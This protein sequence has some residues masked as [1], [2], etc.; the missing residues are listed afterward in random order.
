M[1]VPWLSQVRFLYMVIL[2]ITTALCLLYVAYITSFQLT[3]TASP[4]GTL[5]LS[6]ILSFEENTTQAEVAKNTTVANSSSEAPTVT[7][8]N[9]TPPDLTPRVAAEVLYEAG[10]VD[11]GPQIC[12]DF[13]R[14]LKLLI[15]ITSAPGHESARM[16]IRETW[17]HFAIRNDVAVAFMLGLISNETVNAKIEKEQDLYGDLIRGKFTDTYDNLTL[18]TISLLEWV[19]NYCPEA[20]FLLKTDDDMFINVS[21]LLDFIA[22]RNPEQRT[23]FG[24]LAKKWIPVR[25]RKSKYYVSPNQFKPA[26]F[27]EFTTGP[28]YLLPVHLAKELYL[29][30]LNHTYCKLEDVFITGVVAKNLKIKRVNVPEF[31]NQRVSLTACRVQEGISIHMVEGMEQYDVWKKL[32]EVDPE[33][34]E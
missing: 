33:C 14:D 13:G 24:R 11:F 17:G 28:A 7:T 25:N 2:L 31:L 16:A 8:T 3:R 27:P 21:R 10:H 20:A 6:E 12:P 29:A 32:H 30:A 34:E 5:V 18:K 9:S 4:L 15:A 22:K 26:V 1:G 23:I 19:D